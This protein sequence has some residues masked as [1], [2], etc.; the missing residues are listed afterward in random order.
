MNAPTT[1]DPA[2]TALLVIDMPRDF[3]AVGGYAD[4]AGMDVSRLRAP[5]P[6]IQ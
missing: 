1:F 2:T 3:C 5:F 4:Q 6:A